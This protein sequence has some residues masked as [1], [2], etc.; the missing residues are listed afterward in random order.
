MSVLRNH[1]HRGEP[2]SNENC[3]QQG[4]IIQ[5]KVFQAVMPYDATQH[6]N[7]EDDSNLHCC[8]NLKSHIRESSL[9]K[10]LALQDLRFSQ[11]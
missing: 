3:S 9:S 4:V 2:G 5:V 11:L 10:Y 6:H 1:P 7:P 8:G